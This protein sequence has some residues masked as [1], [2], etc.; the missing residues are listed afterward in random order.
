MTPQGAATDW[1]LLRRAVRDGW[2]TRIERHA[3]TQGRP[4]FDGSH[5]AAYTRSLCRLR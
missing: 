5:G 3:L 1:E 2:P 4:G